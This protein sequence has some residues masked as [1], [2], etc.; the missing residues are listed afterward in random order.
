[1]TQNKHLKDTISLRQGDSPLTY[2]QARREILKQLQVL[3]GLTHLSVVW[4]IART[5]PERRPTLDE[6][7]SALG[8]AEFALRDTGILEG[9]TGRD[10]WR[11][12]D[13]HIDLDWHGGPF[14]YEVV[15]ALL[16]FA[17]DPDT[18]T[19]Y[20]GELSPGVSRCGDLDTVWING[21]RVRFRPYRPIGADA[22]HARAWAALAE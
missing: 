8:A 17:E 10:R 12:I 14:A 15:G 2:Q 22:S 16:R 4:E 5:N 11:T 21:V 20:P 19:V 1:M 18:G 9:A 3:E 13:G 7:R 6:H